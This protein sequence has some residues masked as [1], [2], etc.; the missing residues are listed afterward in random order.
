MI[1]QTFAP[2]DAEL[3]AS[4]AVGAEVVRAWCAVEGDQV[5]ADVIAG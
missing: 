1:L 4:W 2:V 5:P 3:V